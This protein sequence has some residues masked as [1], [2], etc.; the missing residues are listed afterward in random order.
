MEGSFEN[1]RRRRPAVC[2]GAIM[3]TVL[4]AASAWSSPTEQ[5][6]TPQTPRGAAPAVLDEI[7]VT[8]QKRGAE[9]LRDVP[10]SISALSAEDLARSGSTGIQDLFGAV[11]GLAVFDTG[12]NQKKIK[13][14]GVSGSSESEPNETVGIYLDDVSITNAGGTNNENSASP[15]FGVYDLDRIEVLKGPQGTLYGAGSMGGTVRYITRLPD[16]GQFSADTQ[17]RVSSTDSGAGSYG[18]DAMV[19]I[20]LIS[21]R[22]AWRVSGSYDHVGGFIDNAAPEVGVGYGPSGKVAGENNYNDSLT[23]MVRSNILVDFSETA[24]L[25]LKYIHREAD[26]TGLTSVPRTSELTADYPVEPFNHDTMN[27]GDVLVDFRVGDA[28][29]TSSTSYVERNNLARRDLTPLGTG[30]LALISGSAAPAPPLAL[31]NQIHSREFAQEIRVSSAAPGPLQYVAGAYFSYLKKDF[32]QDGP[33]QGLQQ[34]IDVNGSPSAL[35]AASAI[36]SLVLGGVTDYNFYQS[37]VTQD[38]KQIAVFGEATYSFDSKWDLTLGGRYFETKQTSLFTADPAAV[39]VTADADYRDAQLKENGFNPKATLSFKPLGD[40]L[41]LYATVARGFRVGG[42]NQPVSTNPQCLAEFAQI[43]YNPNEQP[44]FKSDTLWSYELGSKTDFGSHRA[45]LDTSIYRINWKNIQLRTPLTCGFTV[46]SNANAA[47]INGAETA[48]SLLI[49][50]HFKMTFSGSYVDARLVSAS[51]ETGGLAGERLLGIPDFTGTVSGEYRFKPMPSFDSYVR[52]D[53]SHV[54][55]YDS[56]F[57]GQL[58]GGAPENRTV[59]NYTLTN[60]HVGTSIA[61]SGWRIEAYAKNLCNVL[62]A[63][64]AQNDIFGDVVFRNR[65]REIGM[66]VGKSF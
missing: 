32:I 21:D 64:G 44:T 5:S 60:L 49:F 29:V 17:A 14:R 62:A 3:S 4:M 45:E 34:W 30:Y 7:L 16:P 66:Q 8:A 10:A 40:D 9:S 23:W 6:S 1:A 38:L 56:Y 11:P 22:A 63:T 51:P 18:G 42:F 33:W 19:N 39:F 26:S 15:D 50:D 59:G 55:S 57:Y 13:L 43:G 46:F 41:M 25:Q 53:V 58:Y 52:V 31:Y 27:I 36:P 37:N 20:P 28:L 12:P 61:G 35:A 54:G 47:R 65:P 24:H 2:K 48:L